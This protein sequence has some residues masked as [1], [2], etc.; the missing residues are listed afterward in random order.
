MLLADFR[1][2]RKL[3]VGLQLRSAGTDDVKSAG[4]AI[5]IDIF[6]VKD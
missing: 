2:N 5:L 1:Y 3:L 6:V 4:I